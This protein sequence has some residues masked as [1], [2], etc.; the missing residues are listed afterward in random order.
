MRQYL[1]TVENHTGNAADGVGGGKAIINSKRLIK[2]Q[3]IPQYQAA[4]K[5]NCLVDTWTRP[6]GFEIAGESSQDVREKP[7][8]Q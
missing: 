2:R 1:N 8:F 7:I 4:L 3:V 6:A 5:C